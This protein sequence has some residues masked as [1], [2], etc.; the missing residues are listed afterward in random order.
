MS[1]KKQMS[2]QTPFCKVC[3][4]AGKSEKEY[5][6]HYVRSAPGPEGKVVCPTLLCQ[7][8]GF[9]GDC[10]HTPKFCP[11][12][13]AEKA[14]EEKAIKQAARRE[15]LEK[16]DAE[17]KAAP[18]AAPVIKKTGFAA[19]FG[20]DSDS[21]TEQ[22]VS[23]KVSKKVSAIVAPMPKPVSAVSVAVR[24]KPAQ[25]IDEFPALNAPIQPA[26]SAAA[27]GS[28]QKPAFM[29]A[30]N[31][32]YP[33]LVVAATTPKIETVKPPMAKLVRKD[34][35]INQYISNKL[36]SDSAY[37]QHDRR[38]SAEL[39]QMD[40][41][42]DSEEDAYAQQTHCN[43]NGYD[44]T[45]YYEEALKTFQAQREPMKASQMN[46]AMEASDSDSDEDW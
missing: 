35:F 42:Y 2:K 29:S 45:A 32:I 25:K 27:A 18:K 11:V 22:K 38:L 30:I 9:C 23:K 21:E 31:K 20:S 12:L 36:A 37:Q 8:C 3:F 5:S 44:V 7:S 15:A 14:A 24:P 19:A 16:R 34:E 43:G 33:E 39:A 26:K 46:W 40:G 17:K 1:S 28:K 10:G 4:D 41:G 13:A 6:N